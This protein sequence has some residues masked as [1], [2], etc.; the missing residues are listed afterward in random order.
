MA[1]APGAGDDSVVAGQVETLM[2]HVRII[3]VGEQ[4][5]MS[6][7]QVGLATG[8]VGLGAEEVNE[9]LPVPVVMTAPC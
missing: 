9:A 1:T 4:Y 3:G 5:R 8:A 2:T 6:P 7:Y